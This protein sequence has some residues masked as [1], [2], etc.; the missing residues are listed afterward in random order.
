MLM[1]AGLIS[2]SRGQM[3]VH[4]PEGLVE[5]SCECYELMERQMDRIFDVPWREL[6]KKEDEKECRVGLRE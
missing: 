6:A 5:G 4:D 2:Y 3:R 1:S